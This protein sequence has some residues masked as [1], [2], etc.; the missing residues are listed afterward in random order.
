VDL[1]E[2]V[3]MA[4]LYPVAA[5]VV[6]GSPKG[7]G[8]SVIVLPGFFTGPNHTLLL[9]T[10]LGAANY[11]PLDWG[12]GFNMGTSDQIARDLAKL[13]KLTHAQYGKVS[14]VGWSLGGL[15]ARALANGHPAQVNKLI[16]LGS[17]HKADPKKSKL[18]PV[19][20]LL[21]PKKLHSMDQHDLDLVRKDPPVPIT[22][23]YTKSDEVVD[24]QDCL[25]DTAPNVKNVEVQSTHLTLT[26]NIE[27]L[28][29]I[30]AAL[31]A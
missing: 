27:A 2:A 31:A 18:A 14:L 26:H 11:R 19:F 28:R 8:H 23:I 16:T 9:R 7:D 30:L 20:D 3:A 10:A 17:P 22:N 15:L 4:A 5:T 6:A 12:E 1:F 29:A 25:S 24:W 21:S 13:L